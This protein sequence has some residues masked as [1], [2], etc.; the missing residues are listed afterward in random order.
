MK[1]N[2]SKVIGIKGRD[3]RLE[4]KD[5]VD[6]VKISN[7][8]VC[9]LFVFLLTYVALGGLAIGNIIA[10]PVVEAILYLL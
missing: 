10:S 1:E 7:V 5:I 8:T 9:T 2:T 4:L 6:T 3:K